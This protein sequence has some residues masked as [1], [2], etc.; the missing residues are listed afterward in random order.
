MDVKILL[1]ACTAR[2]YSWPIAS[3]SSTHRSTSRPRARHFFRTDVH[4]ASQ[5]QSRAQRSLHSAQ[6]VLRVESRLSGLLDK[7]LRA[8]SDGA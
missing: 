3:R 1:A 8:V 4:V 5:S 7:I 2:G 6:M